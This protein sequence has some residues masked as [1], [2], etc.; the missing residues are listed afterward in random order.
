[1][2]LRIQAHYYYGSFWESGDAIEHSSLFI[3]HFPALQQALLS[4]SQAKGLLGLKS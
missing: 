1:M 4:S 2:P 3:V